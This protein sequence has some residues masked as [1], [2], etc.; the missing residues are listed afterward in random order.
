VR[1][2]LL[3]IIEGDRPFQVGAGV[4]KISQEEQRLPQSVV[5]DNEA[6]WIVHTLH[7][8]EALLCQL[9]RLS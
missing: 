5:G 6:R 2:S 3:G 9:P 7:Q 8:E 4:D 1:P